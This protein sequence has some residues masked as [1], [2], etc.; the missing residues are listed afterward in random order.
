M[1]TFYL[2]RSA[3]LKGKST[4]YWEQFEGLYAFMRNVS[5]S[6]FA[7]ALLYLGWS[8][9]PSLWSSG[10]RPSHY[11]LITVLVLIIIVLFRAD[12]LSTAKP[13]TYDAQKLEKLVR[14][15]NTGG[16]HPQVSRGGFSFLWA[17]RPHLFVLQITLALA[18]CSGGWFVGR[19]IGPTAPQLTKSSGFHIALIANV[20]PSTAESKDAPGL[21]FEIERRGFFLLILALILTAASV[22]CH[23]AYR[24]FS[25]EFAVNVWRDFANIDSPKPDELHM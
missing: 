12:R 2:A 10:L 16:E 8:A 17:E 15:D 7:A 19:T 22:R 1:E 14:T 6:L 4:S 3:L 11:L 9:D 21:H 25:K 18:L 13:S 5:F 20:L 24:L 23:G